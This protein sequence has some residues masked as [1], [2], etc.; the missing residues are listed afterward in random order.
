MAHLEANALGMGNLPLV[1]LPHPLGTL[2]APAVHAAVDAAL[3]AVVAALLAPAA[4]GA[5]R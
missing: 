2:P 1:V 5:A 4:V 3:D